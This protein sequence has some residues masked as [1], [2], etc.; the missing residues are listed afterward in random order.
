MKNKIHN[1]NHILDFGKYKGEKIS[2]VPD[3]YLEWMIEEFE[4]DY[5][6]ELAEKEMNWR[7]ENGG[8]I[9]TIRDRRE[10][11]ECWIGDGWGEF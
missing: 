7:Y 6:A 9:E 11:Q 1:R 10:S 3:S 4:V 8:H 5:W 2:E